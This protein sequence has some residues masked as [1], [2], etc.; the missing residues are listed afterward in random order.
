MF[1]KAEFEVFFA[2]ETGKAPAC[3]SKML[4]GWTGTILGASKA[5]KTAYQSL[6]QDPA[7]KQPLSWTAPGFTLSEYSLVFLPGGHEKGMRQIMDSVEAHQMLASYF[8]SAK[9]PSPRVVAAICHGPQVLAAACL[10]N[11][12]GKSV[13][14]DCIT[15]G[16]PH[17]ME[18]GIYHATRVL[19]GDYYKTYGK[20][21]D[22]VQSAVTKRLREPS[23]FKS[24]L[25]ISP[26][27]FAHFDL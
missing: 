13:L 14:H 8:H 16:L 2:T 6:I 18:Q 7:F 27:V 3:D 20:G 25:S 4:S 23:Q 21:S 24:S 9:K 22:S 15:T 19:L 10:E 26:Y 1:R 11:G 12:T 5:A 17:T